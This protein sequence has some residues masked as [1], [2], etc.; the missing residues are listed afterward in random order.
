MAGNVVF[1]LGFILAILF[2]LSAGQNSTADGAK[3][4]PAHASRTSWRQQDGR[5]GHKTQHQQRHLDPRSL[6]SVSRHG[7]RPRP[8]SGNNM[9][10][11]NFQALHGAS[12]SRRGSTYSRKPSSAASRV[13]RPPSKAIYT[14]PGQKFATRN[15]SKHRSDQAIVSNPR[16][17]SLRHPSAFIGS[18]QAQEN[19]PTEIVVPA[20]LSEASSNEESRD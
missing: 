17:R 8:S 9:S 19:A 7:G 10:L 2:P 11:I 12:S 1:T 16:D 5:P 4:L 6:G 20:S 15:P 3:V 13:V 18:H 14:H